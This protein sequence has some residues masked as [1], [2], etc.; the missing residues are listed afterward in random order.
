MASNFRNKLEEYFFYI[1]HC[2]E[3]KEI[4]ILTDKDIF[5]I[6]FTFSKYGNEDNSLK[7]VRLFVFYLL[8]YEQICELVSKIKECEVEHEITKEDHLFLQYNLFNGEFDMVNSLIL[9]IIL[10]VDS[11]IAFK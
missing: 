7:K 11:Q 1:D 4:K 5:L 2:E 10:F 8:I 9:I 3:E 6:G